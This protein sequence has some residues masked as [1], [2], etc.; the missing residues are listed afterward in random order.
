MT[1]IASYITKFGIIQASD[2]NLTSDSG[3]VG[4]GQK[5][6]PIPHL[7]A[8]LA[9]SGVYSIN[10]QRIDTWIN[11]FVSGAFFT[12]NSIEE[13]AKQLA[14]RMTSEMR[15]NEISEISIVHIAGYSK[16]DDQSHAEHWHIANTTLNEDGSYSAA[17]TEFHY[18]NDFNSRINPD[19]RKLLVQFDSNSSY[20]QYYI[21]GFPPGRM[22]SVAIKQSIDKTLNSIWEQQ[23]TWKFNRPDNIFE[24]STLVKLYFDFVIRLFPMSDYP[25][26]YIGGEIQTHLIPAPQNL[27]K[28]N[29]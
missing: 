3:N 28:I 17:K 12:A 14:N 13:F 9:Y 10:G 6:F 1:L 24:F 22:S 19:Q 29:G 20:H 21:N 16:R 2:S 15:E 7:N 8:S 5:I 26:M 25:A 27:W 11:N 18:H 4:F 23:P